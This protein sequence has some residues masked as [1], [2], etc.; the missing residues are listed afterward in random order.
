MS[1]YERLKSIESD[2]DP[3]PLG[4]GRLEIAHSEDFY[5]RLLE[6]NDLIRLMGLQ[7]AY[8]CNECLVE[9]TLPREH[10]NTMDLESGDV[11]A[12]YDSKEWIVGKLNARP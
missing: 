3:C 1:E 10:G 11:I 7:S 6:N 8:R 4:G 2:L 9:F 12:Q 5:D